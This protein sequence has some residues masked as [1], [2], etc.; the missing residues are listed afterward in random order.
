[1]PQIPEQI[2]PY[3][4]A[5]AKYHFWI[6]A[7]IVPIVLV[8]LLFQGT[9]ALDTLINGQKSQIDGRISALNAVRGIAEHPNE[10]WSEAVEQ[11]TRK[12][13]DET[14]AEWQTFWTEQ[15]PLRIWSSKLGEPF[16][17]A[18]AALKPGG[19]LKK[20]F[21]VRYQNT[22]PELVREL[23][24]RMGSDDFMLEGSGPNAVGLDS[25]PRPGFGGE[26]GGRPGS[27]M[28]PRPGIGQPGAGSNALVEWS[29]TDQKRLFDSFKWEKPPS[30][31]QVLLAQEELWAYGILCDVI[32]KA[33]DGAAGPFESPIGLVSELAVGYPAAE[34][35][36]GGQGGGRVYVAAAPAAGGG[37]FTGEAIAS[38]DMSG[39]M[40]APAGRPSNPRFSGASGGGPMGRGG[41]FAGGEGG[42]DPSAAPVVSPDDQL[43]EWIYVDFSGKPLT[44]AE[45][46]TVP[47]AKLVHLMPFVLRVTMDQRKLDALLANLATNPVPIDVRQV[48]I[49]PSQQA[50][51]AGPMGRGEFA[52][53][54]SMP[55][56]GG[57]GSAGRPFDVVV[58][59]RGT[60]GLA[61]PPDPSAIGGGDAPAGEGGA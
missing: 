26:F 53:S 54:P 56:D 46:A 20:E 19:A 35:Q 14:L 45:L 48:R 17:K 58:E 29:A 37:E 24:K 7:A 61:P 13:R 2:R 21:L 43:K 38:P 8:P 25:P 18:V 39:G 41:E 27:D 32:K 28:G 3:V 47:A 30:T 12:I 57:A 34:D 1:M 10:S 52:A 4:A 44:A 9:T 31:T 51:G 33:N 59:L 36:P 60:V 22:V 55:V 40:G 5:V 50:G 6:L 42:A 23:P 15:T 49:N 11:Q 16:Q